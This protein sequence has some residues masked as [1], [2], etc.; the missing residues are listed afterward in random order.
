MKSEA[1]AHTIIRSG[2][3]QHSIELLDGT[4]CTTQPE[5]DHAVN[6][7]RQI[8]LFKLPLQRLAIQASGCAA[9]AVQ[10]VR[11]LCNLIDR[12]YGAAGELGYFS[13]DLGTRSLRNSARSFGE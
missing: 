5:L 9:S 6:N 4:L 10:P 8:I 7:W 3:E 12:G 1:A 11:Q 13:V 2:A